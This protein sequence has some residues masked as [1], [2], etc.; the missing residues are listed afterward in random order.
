[1]TDDAF[2]DDEDLCEWCETDDGEHAELCPTVTGVTVEELVVDPRFIALARDVL[3]LLDEL[4]NT[5][6]HAIELHRTECLEHG[7]TTEGDRRLWSVLALMRERG[8]NLH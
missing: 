5:L 7:P 6:G 1:M 2:D 3:V 4:V 8:Y